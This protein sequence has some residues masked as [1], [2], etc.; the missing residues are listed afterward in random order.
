MSLESEV[1]KRKRGTSV[2]Y[3]PQCNTIV[4]IY[5]PLLEKALYHNIMLRISPR[6]QRRRFH[7][8]SFLFFSL[9]FSPSTFSIS[10]RPAFYKTVPCSIRWNDYIFFPRLLLRSNPPTSLSLSLS[11]CGI[12]YKTQLSCLVRYWSLRFNVVSTKRERERHTL[13]IH[14]SYNS[15]S[16]PT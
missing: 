10:F 11:A 13:Q 2:E 1:R 15:M 3:Q 12:K 5:K 4:E 14:S 7:P 9:S 16:M 6:Y 8:P